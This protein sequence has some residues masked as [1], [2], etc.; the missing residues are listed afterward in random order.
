M[1]SSFVFH[2]RNA[3][4]GDVVAVL[5]V[6]EAHPG[7]NTIAEIV[8]QADSLGFS[9]RDRARLEALMT[10]REL[11]F[12]EPDKNLLTDNGKVIAEL[13]MNKPDLF[14]DIVHGYQYT[15]WD[16]RKS[17]AHCFS[18]T[19]REICKYLWQQESVQVNSQ[20]K[21]D[22][23][24]EI[25]GSARMQFEHSDI[26]LSAK[27]VGGAFL[28]L[29]EL[30]PNVIDQASELFTR[31]TFCPPELFS[32]GVDFIY[33]SNEIDYGANLLL[34]EEQCNAICQV[35]LLAPDSFDRVLEY[36]TTQ[37]DYLEKGIGGGW[38]RYLTL[39][40]APALGDFV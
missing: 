25:E 32:L 31:R 16:K 40:R 8:S 15:L 20:G 28:W 33:R 26:A 10:A 22:L 38:G 27:S 30:A 24:S 21:K 39:H 6:L 35:C 37:F 14:P 4:P 36:S 11:G 7:L 29:E 2:I 34:G 5:A 3:H 18:W 12:V 19:Y 23:A 1:S 13:E 9:I 17:S